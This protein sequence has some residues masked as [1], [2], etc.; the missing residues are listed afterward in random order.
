VTDW[1]RCRVVVPV[2]V[3]CLLWGQIPGAFSQ[4]APKP[5]FSLLVSPTRLVIPAGTRAATQRFLVRNEGRSP[6]TVTVDKAD[7]TTSE[8]GALNFRRNAPYAAA[9]WAQVTPTRFRMAA[10]TSKQV[11]FHISPPA[12]AE[13]G[14][15]QFALIFKVPAGRSGANI[16]IN[17]G[18]ATPVFI[19]VPGPVDSS[20]EVMSLRAPGFAMRG[21]VF[22]TTKI[23]DLGTVH[24]DFRGKGRLR[25][26]VRGSVFGGGMVGFPDFTVLRD[27]SREVTA[28]WN[29]PLM[30]V[31]HVTVALPGPTGTAGPATVRI[32]VVPVHLLASSAGVLLT[33]VFLGWYARRRYRAKVRAAAIALGQDEGAREKAHGG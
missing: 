28:R 15:H 31:C 4:T 11:T 16:K 17:R 21:P 29:P 8:N 18:I 12:D 6:F 13:P 24:R 25:A 1:L 19:A 23:R 10:G 7:F 32:V 22:L 27:A 9:A 5:G 26:T 30:C 20:A 14:D 33:L 3:I 2:G